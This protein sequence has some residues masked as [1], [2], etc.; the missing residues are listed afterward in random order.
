MEQNEPKKLNIK[1]IRLKPT[2]LLALILVCLIALAAMIIPQRIRLHAAEQQLKEKQDELAKVKYKYEQERKNLDYMRTDTYK[3][4]QGLAKY[5]WH[6]KA[7]TLI[8]DREL[9]N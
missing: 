8:E 1:T 9:G 6:Y 5:G 3:V 7:D 2:Y 4:Q